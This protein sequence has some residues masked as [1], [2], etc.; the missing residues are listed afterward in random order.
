MYR[1]IFPFENTDKPFTRALAA[2]DK[3]YGRMDVLT[4]EVMTK[5][6]RL[7]AVAEKDLEAL[8]NFSLEVNS[9]ISHMEA[10]GQPNGLPLMKPHKVWGET[11]G[12]QKRYRLVC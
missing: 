6:K 5:I 8:H 1:V 2:L 10:V 4:D 3:R 12:Y 9:K 7:P 11:F